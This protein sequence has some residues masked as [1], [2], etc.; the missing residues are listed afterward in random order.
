MNTFERLSADVIRHEIAPYLQSTKWCQIKDEQNFLVLCLYKGISPKGEDHA[1]VQRLFGRA[2]KQDKLA[3]AYDLIDPDKWS[4]LKIKP[5]LDLGE[6][7][8]AQ[9]GGYSLAVCRSTHRASLRV[10]R[11]L[12]K[13][14][15]IPQEYREAAIG[16]AILHDRP[17][18][19]IEPLLE[20]GPISE[21]HRYSSICRAIDSYNYSSAL[22]AIEA[23]QKDCAF[24][25]RE[26]N[27]I[28]LSVVYHRHPC[29]PE[30]LRALLKDRSLSES[31]V[32]EV[33]I[34]IISKSPP[35]A[36]EI[37]R[38]VLNHMS[39]SAQTCF[40]A[41]CYIEGAGSDEAVEIISLLLDNSATDIS[42]GRKFFRDALLSHMEESKHPKAKEILG[43]LEVDREKH[44]KWSQANRIS[45]K[46]GSLGLPALSPSEPS[47][48]GRIM[49]QQELITLHLDNMVKHAPKSSPELI[50]ELPGSGP[51]RFLRV[52]QKAL[53]ASY[54]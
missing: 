37:V 20:N 12:L 45:F 14:G 36:V 28:I 44:P 35:R 6:L 52:R 32:I 21:S 47:N 42:E 9:K 54:F 3:V 17:A 38:E 25:E 48:E 19:R 18:E 41:A 10:L 40:A 33:I 46:A 39:I 4:K 49:H 43:L 11:E 34:D 30:I 29:A 1:V 7:S 15:P 31:I 22:E 13:Q 16:V 50:I 5:P 51:T 26:L 23:L 53:Q 27:F 24:S 2:I 8:P